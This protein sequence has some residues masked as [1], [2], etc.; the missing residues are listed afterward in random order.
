MVKA[1]IGQIDMA[2]GDHLSDE[3][4]GDNR[5]GGKKFVCHDLQVGPWI[6]M[7]LLRNFKI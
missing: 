2:G 3:Q 6:F 4:P 1:P 7:S 5:F